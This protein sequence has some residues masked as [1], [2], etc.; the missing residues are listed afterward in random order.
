MRSSNSGN[1]KSASNI[2]RGEAA[3]VGGS[4]G[5]GFNGVGGTNAGAAAA[6]IWCGIFGTM[7]HHRRR[8]DGIVVQRS[9]GTVDEKHAGRLGS[10][11]RGAVDEFVSIANVPIRGIP[12]NCRRADPPESIWLVDHNEYARLVH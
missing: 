11:F 7:A 8:N 3:S 1:E 9:V 12:R 5:V 4:N 10:G 2:G 6:D